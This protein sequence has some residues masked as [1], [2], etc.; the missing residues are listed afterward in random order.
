MDIDNWKRR[1]FYVISYEFFAIIFS[2][3][4]LAFFTNSTAAYSTPVAIII[5]F[6]AT[7][8]NFIYNTAF[9]YWESRQKIKGRSLLRRS[10][11]AVGYEAGL[12]CFIIPVYMWWYKVGIFEAL[13]MEIFILLFFFAYSFSFGLMFDRLFGL[14]N[15]AK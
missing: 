8:W 13:S 7:S 4:I 10:I 2:S 15:S 11:Q 5:S 3:F 14:P 6:A 1:I 9:E 12:I